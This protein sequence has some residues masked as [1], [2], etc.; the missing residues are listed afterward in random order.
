[1]EI[2]G[3]RVLITGANRG[4]G[5]ALALACAEAGAAE[6]IAAAREL[7]GVEAGDGGGPQPRITQARLDVTS[8]EQ[9]EAAARRVGAV[10]ILINNAGIA[11]FGGVFKAGL[12][13]VRREMEVNYLGVLRVVRAF[14]PAMAERG[15]GLIV[16]IASQLS[17]V[18]LPA[19]GTYCATKAALLSLSQAMRGDLAP[20]GVR[21]ISVLPCTI[22][23]D[24]SRG[25]DIPKI[26]VEAAAAEILEAIR[27]EAR[28]T[29]IGDEARQLLSS[30][31]A[32][33]V[34]VEQ[35]FSQF[36]A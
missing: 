13:D 4:L 17:K 15:D 28:E 33:P 5:R 24:M 27:S 34:A 8:D 10:D 12:E 32:D 29:M 14:A 7:H 22:D 31:A 20:S 35:A 21:V 11:V 6:V 23:T 3:R 30:L 36:R 25:Y 2:T 9:V 26:P 16:N 1:M 18:S 19:L